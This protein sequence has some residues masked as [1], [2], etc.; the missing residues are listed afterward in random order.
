MNYWYLQDFQMPPL[1]IPGF[2]SRRGQY[3]FKACI[4]SLQAPA[5]C[6]EPLNEIGTVVCYKPFKA[7]ELFAYSN[8]LKIFY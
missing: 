8:N 3:K 1:G 7:F 2:F 6:S 4:I 5:Y